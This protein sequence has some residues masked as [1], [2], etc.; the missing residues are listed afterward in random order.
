MIDSKGPRVRH[1]LSPYDWFKLRGA[2]KH[3][4]LEKRSR[5][6]TQTDFVV[7]LL[8]EQ[9]AKFVA[10]RAKQLGVQVGEDGRCAGG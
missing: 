3:Q 5:Y 7:V 9:A 2:P 8:L 1:A 4:P 6:E 10:T